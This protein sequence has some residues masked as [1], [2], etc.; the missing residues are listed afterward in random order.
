MNIL[1]SLESV[2]LLDTFQ[3]PQLRSGYTQSVVL[4]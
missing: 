3:P 1:S 2:Q 4:S